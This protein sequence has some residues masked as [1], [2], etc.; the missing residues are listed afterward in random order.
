MPNRDA[1]GRILPPDPAAATRQEGEARRIADL[2]AP[3]PDRIVL[4]R[5]GER[6][7]GPGAPSQMSIVGRCIEALTRRSVADRERMAATETRLAQA[8][9]RIAELEAAQS[10]TSGR[11]I[12]VP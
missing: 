7:G 6:A 4:A 11:R 3:A 2:L 1:L 5:A 10:A 12:I 9:R 8:E